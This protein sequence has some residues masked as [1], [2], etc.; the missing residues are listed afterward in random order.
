[1]NNQ[2]EC[3]KAGL[4]V[5]NHRGGLSSVNLDVNKSN[6]NLNAKEVSHILKETG[7]KRKKAI[8]AACRLAGVSRMHGED[9]WPLASL[10]QK[11][12]GLGR[13]QKKGKRPTVL[14]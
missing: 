2:S 3:I 12:K 4:K 13:D 9:V 5:S 11:K 8:S 10:G 7:H 6:I 1:M 14:L